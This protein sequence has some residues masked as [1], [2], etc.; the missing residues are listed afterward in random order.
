MLKFNEK[1]LNTMCVEVLEGFSDTYTALLR[2]TK[3]EVLQS[4]GI[5]RDKSRSL[6]LGVLIEVLGLT[7]ADLM[8]IEDVGDG[9]LRG[10]CGVDMAVM[11]T[12]NTELTK[13]LEKVVL[14]VLVKSMKWEDIVQSR[15]QIYVLCGLKYDKMIAG[16]I[17]E[18]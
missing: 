17:D 12:L 8:I 9:Q 4:V 13:I 15:L 2:Y 7:E 10:Y 5:S 14:D 16:M 18:A 3:D 11:G 1:K 6:Y